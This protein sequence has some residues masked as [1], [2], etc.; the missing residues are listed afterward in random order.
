MTPNNKSKT[1]QKW[2][3]CFF[4]FLLH[5]LC[6]TKSHLKVNASKLGKVTNHIKHKTK[7]HMTQ[8]V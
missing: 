6:F 4:F 8:E 7:F 3:K 2:A 5:E 1:A